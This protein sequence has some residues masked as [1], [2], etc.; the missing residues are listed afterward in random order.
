[1]YNTDSSFAKG[2]RQFWLVLVEIK[3]V[4]LCEPTKIAILRPPE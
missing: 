1:M 4:I 2:L 3:E